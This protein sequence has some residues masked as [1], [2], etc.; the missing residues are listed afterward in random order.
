MPI[1]LEALG[2]I[3]RNRRKSIPISQSEV[4]RLAGT[5][6]SY[7]SQLEKG[8]QPNPTMATLNKIAQAI[9]MDIEELMRVVS[10]ELASTE[11]NTT[12]EKLSALWKNISSLPEDKIEEICRTLEALIEYHRPKN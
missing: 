1:N 2:N 8:Q 11:T 12:S 10:G 4:A 9:Q 3:I 7:I 5:S 6:Q